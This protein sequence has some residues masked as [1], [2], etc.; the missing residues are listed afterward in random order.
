[1]NYSAFSQLSLGWM[2]CV[3]SGGWGG[4]GMVAGGSSCPKRT[5]SPIEKIRINQEIVKIRRI[6]CVWDTKHPQK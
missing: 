2:G 3:R 4:E 5:L 1:M 6:T